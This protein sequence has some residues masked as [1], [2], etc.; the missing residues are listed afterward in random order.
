MVNM[1]EFT[2]YRQPNGSYL[3]STLPISASKYLAEIEKKFGRRDH[4]FSLLGIDFDATPGSKP[5]NWF[6]N[7]GIPDNDP[8]NRSRHIIIHLAA[9][10]IG[11]PAIAEWQP[12]HECVHLLD[13]WNRAIDGGPTNILEEGLATWYQC[14]CVPMITVNDDRYKEALQLVT[15]YENYLPSAI[16]TI[17]E[18]E[19]NRHGKS[20]RIGDIT[21]KVLRAYCGEITEM[22]ADRLCERFE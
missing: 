11:N 2:T 12:A 16:K 4:S 3:P 7:S 9:N 18:N 8:E 13:P 1:M 20:L 5:R 22:D 14:K 6:L 15:R 17:R 19:Q 10:A 21:P